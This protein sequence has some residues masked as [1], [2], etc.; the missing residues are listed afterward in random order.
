MVKTM[1]IVSLEYL[2]IK[3]TRR[4][5]EVLTEC[6]VDRGRAEILSRRAKELPLLIQQAG[7]FQAVAF[8]ISKTTDDNKLYENLYKLLNPDQKDV[9]RDVNSICNNIKEE[10]SKEGKGYTF[11]LAV[12][13]HAISKY[14]DQLNVQE[15]KSTE[16][17]IKVVDCM[18]KLHEKGLLIQFERA[19]NPYLIT[20]KR[21]FEALY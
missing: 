12:L 5:C 10:V 21:L 7:L 1:S 14:S 16:N 4:A 3:I 17:I 8:Y 11:L 20:I 2:A 19:L 15:C 18:L 6:N 9:D 13:S